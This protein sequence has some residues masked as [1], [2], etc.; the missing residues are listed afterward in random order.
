MANTKYQQHVEELQDEL[1]EALT[2]RIRNGEKIVVRTKDGAEIAQQDCSAQTLGVALRLLQ[3]NGVRARPKP[4][5]RLAQL[6]GAIEGDA[7]DVS[8]EFPD[9]IN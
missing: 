6:Q 8:Y 5:S 2:N 7:P 4:G 1:I 9:S 3:H